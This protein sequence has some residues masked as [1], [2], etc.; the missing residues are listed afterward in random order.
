M[1]RSTLS[2]YGDSHIAAKGK[3]NGETGVNDGIAGKIVVLK[4][5]AP[6]S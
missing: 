6:F 4:N 2:D 1:W 5:N 3:M